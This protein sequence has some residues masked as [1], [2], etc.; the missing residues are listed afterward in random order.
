M[1][2]L[3]NNQKGVALVTVLLAITVVSILFT[4][5]MATQVNEMKG[6]SK[7]E[8]HIKKLHILTGY[9]E[10]VAYIFLTNDSLTNHEALN[11]LDGCLPKND[12][13]FILSNIETIDEFTLDSLS[14]C[15]KN[16]NLE[17]VA[18][19]ESTTSTKLIEKNNT[20]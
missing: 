2:F 1:N 19:H 13:D 4:S 10:E 14:I 15:H 12:I 5:I 7:F 16:N 6:Q 3:I 17:I 20:D 9:T 8:D 11:E 18:T